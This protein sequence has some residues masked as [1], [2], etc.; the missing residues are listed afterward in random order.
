MSET[1]HSPRNTAQTLAPQAISEEVLLEKYSKGDE[2]N[3]LDIN[4]RVAHALAQAEAP[5]QRALWEDK[6]L[7]ALQQGFLPAAPICLPR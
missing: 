1:V 7:H 2:K 5:E 4:Q 3:I 6:F